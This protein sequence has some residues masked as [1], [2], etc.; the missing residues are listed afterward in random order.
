MLF[1]THAHL[2]DEQLL[3]RTDELVAD[4]RRH[5]VTRILTVSTS[6][7][8]CYRSLQLAG[9]F[10][11]VYAAVGIHPNCCHEALPAHWQEIGK[12]IDRPGVVALGETGL[13]RYWD[14]CPWE[15]QQEYFLRHIRLSRDS[16]LPFIVH[17]RDCETEM[18]ATLDRAREGGTLHGVMHSFCGS[19]EAARQF[20]EWGMYISF[21]GM[22]TFK[23]N[24][25]L[26]ESAAGIP[27]DRL[28]VET[29]SPYLSPHPCRSQRPNTPALVRYTLQCL[30]EARGVPEQ[31]L[32]RRTTENALRLFGINA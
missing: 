22:V 2:D 6:L 24:H 11:G 30:A 27:E 32:A 4:A 26:R 17:M 10:E 18:L 15:L 25:G 23:K 7:A 1:D 21:A 3:G 20:L 29:D 8:S 19:A 16:G 9:Q 31:D 12:L 14:F 28:L 13:D 5:G